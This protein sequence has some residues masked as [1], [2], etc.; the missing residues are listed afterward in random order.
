[1]STGEGED[2][3]NLPGQ[4]DGDDRASHGGDR[5]GIGG[6][7]DSV[8]RIQ[9]AARWAEAY[10]KQGDSLASVLKRF[11]IAYEYIDAVIH[12]VDTP[13]LDSELAE[14]APAPA[15][16]Y[17]PPP[18][19]SDPAPAPPAESPPPPPEQRPWG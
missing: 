10:A 4:R 6:G 11:R 16:A 9:L 17:A 3:R 13:E 19:W 7:D 18:Q 2:P 15:A 1:M 12:G 8:S 5:I 14:P